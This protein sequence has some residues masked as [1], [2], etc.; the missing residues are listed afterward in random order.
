M[1]VGYET[2]VKQQAASTW[3]HPCLCVQCGNKITLAG[4][5][6]VHDV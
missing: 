1:E 4:M 2:P 6:M 5:L 3:G